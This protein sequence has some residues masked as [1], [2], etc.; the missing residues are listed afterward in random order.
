MRRMKSEEGRAVE[1]VDPL[2]FFLEVGGRDDGHDGLRCRGRR[3][4]EDL[5]AVELGN[6]APDSERLGTD[7]GLSAARTDGGEARERQLLS[8]DAEPAAADGN[9]GLYWSLTATVREKAP[10]VVVRSIE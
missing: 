6:R 7:R 2:A 8:F 10:K 9:D 1:P 4:G 5:A 3:F